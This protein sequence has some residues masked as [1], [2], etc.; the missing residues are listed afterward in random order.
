MAAI[1]ICSD[2]GA[3]KNCQPLF[4]L[5]PHLFA[6][7]WWDRVPW[8]ILVQNLIAS[9]PLILCDLFLDNPFYLLLNCN[10]LIVVHIHYKIW[11]NYIPYFY[12]FPKNFN[13]F[14]FYMQKKKC[15]VAYFKMFL[16]DRIFHQMWPYNI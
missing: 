2:F 12:F 5:F 13:L 14:I 8:S 4:A 11:K 7:K 10:D 16:N 3:Q 9:Y 15:S 6:M 1:T